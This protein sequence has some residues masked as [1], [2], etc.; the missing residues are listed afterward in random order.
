MTSCLLFSLTKI[1]G[2]ESLSS[3]LFGPLDTSYQPTKLVN[4]QSQALLKTGNFEIALDNRSNIEGDEPQVRLDAKY[5][6][7]KY[8]T[9]GVSSTNH[10]GTYDI[11]A[12]T[13]ILPLISDSNKHSFKLIY[14]MNLGLHTE[15]DIKFDKKDQLSF[16]HQLIIDPQLS[17]KFSIHLL[18]TYIHKN[19]ADTSEVN[20][21][22]DEEGR[23]TEIDPNFGHPWDMMFLGIG[24][25]WNFNKSIKFI[26]EYFP[27][28]NE[29]DG[30]TED[31]G[32]WALGIDY[33]T[34]FIIMQLQ[35]SNILHLSERSLMDDVGID[36]PNGN[37]YL[38]MKLSRSFN[39]KTQYEN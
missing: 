13:N 37:L 3:I 2:Q 28:I 39:L 6:L 7:S 20:T 11:S 19:I 35:L 18:P 5:G 17:S 29:Q 10:L 15:I 4:A 22:K 1:N 27:L 33:Y 38:G 25:S 8:L 9:L 24:G 34:P 30:S 31:V 23:F 21:E 16:F 26:G 36:P 12:K 32:G 14:Y